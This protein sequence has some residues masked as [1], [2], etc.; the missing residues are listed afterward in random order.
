[1]ARRCRPPRRLVLHRSRSRPDRPAT[2]QNRASRSPGLGGL[3][4]A[5][6]GDAAELMVGSWPLRPASW[7][8]VKASIAVDSAQS[9]LMV[10][11]LSPSR[12]WTRKVVLNHLVAGMMLLWS[13]R[14]SS[15]PSTP[16]S[17]HRSPE[18]VEWLSLDRLVVLR[19]P[20]AAGLVSA[21]ARR[22]F[23][24]EPEEAAANV[25]APPRRMAGSVLALNGAASV[26]GFV[27]E[28]LV[29]AVVP[30]TELGL[31]KHVGCWASSSLP[32][33]ATPPSTPPRRTSSV[34]RKGCNWSLGLRHRDGI[35]RCRSACSWRR[36]GDWVP[37]RHA[38][39]TWSSRIARGVGGDAVGDGGVVVG[40]STA[41]PTGS[42]R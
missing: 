11:G 41:A 23:D 34:A 9:L 1:M 22:L 14:W 35:R 26:I 40:C 29:G 17:Q 4:N 19:W 37:Y 42:R 2:E 7:R 25:A 24:A 15:E 5:T 30:R 36:A 33:S 12:R 38:M 39:G 8:C 28:I 20:P 3:M 18:H 6:F 21:R 13:W 10:L 16:A 27:S 31:G 32:W